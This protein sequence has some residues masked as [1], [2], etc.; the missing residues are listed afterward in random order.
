MK[1]NRKK[2]KHLLLQ[3]LTIFLTAIPVLRSNAS[4]QADK[5]LKYYNYSTNTTDLKNVEIFVI[6]ETHTVKLDKQM[7]NLIIK[8]YAQQGDI[9]LSEGTDENDGSTKLV[10]FNAELAELTNQRT[11]YIEGWDNVNAFKEEILKSKIKS[12]LREKLAAADSSLLTKI[13]SVLKIKICSRDED[14]LIDI[15][16]KSLND[17]IKLESLRS[18]HSKIFIIAG[19]YHLT[20]NKELISSL[21]STGRNFITL[22]PNKSNLDR[23]PIKTSNEHVRENFKIVFKN[24][25]LKQV[26]LKGESE[27]SWRDQW[28]CQL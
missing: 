12:V 4:P 5:I 9:L 19:S 11:M 24:K 6:G 2:I 22:V 13:I 1:R 8:T 16:N 23:V 28:T 10:L 27:S 21:K 15:R 17:K 26:V 3:Y 25:T 14:K 20:N 7:E 18:P